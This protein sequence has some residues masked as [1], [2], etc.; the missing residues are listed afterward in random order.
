MNHTLL[1]SLKKYTTLTSKTPYL[2][3]YKYCLRPEISDKGTLL[4]KMRKDLHFKFLTL[5]P[6]LGIM[7]L[8]LLYFSYDSVVNH[9]DYFL[10]IL[11]ISLLIPAFFVFTKARQ[12]T[13]SS[14]ELDP[15]TKS[16]LT[17][18]VNG[19][20]YQQSLESVSFVQNKLGNSITLNC[21]HNPKTSD[22]ITIVEQKNNNLDE[23][24][25]LA[26]ELASTFNVPLKQKS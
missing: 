24:K 20:T 13:T 15:K 6:R 19:E 5:M 2:P 23:V 26:E 17:T 25:S 21:S 9:N 22:T 14:Y 3:F 12:T 11:S 4:F 18:Q 1:E 16:V 8:I 10:L 7:A